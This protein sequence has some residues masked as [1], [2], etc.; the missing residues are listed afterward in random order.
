MFF[1][2][3]DYENIL[4]YIRNKGIKDSD[5]DEL[6]FP[7]S[8]EEYCVLTRNGKNYKVKIKNIYINPEKL[9]ISSNGTWV[10]NGED[11]GIQ[12]R[13][14]K[15]EKG[16]K[17]YLRYNVETGYIEYSYDQSAWENLISKEEFAAAAT[18][19]IG[20][21]TYS[22]GAHPNV[23]NSGTKAGAV[24]DFTLPDANTII[25]RNTK[26]I[27]PGSKA[28]VVNAGTSYDVVL[29]FNIPQG[30]KG[31]IGPKGDGFQ[32][33]G[34]VNDV[35]SL[36]SSG[37]LGD[38]YMVGTTS[39]YHI[40]MYNGSAYVDLGTATEIKAGVFDGGRADSVYGG[41][42]TVDCGGAAIE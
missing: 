6:G 1:T 40:Y 3:E 42:R 9:T 34:F 39:P 38:T 33:S 20:K 4:K 26:T 25:V 23:V 14:D 37:F 27:A 12:A 32:I 36:P 29:D 13:G 22:K 31:P 21:V 19:E 30:E 10:V 2:R 11:T 18:I 35:S 8:G 28:T 17:P 41:A 24:F 16:D 15:G 5:F 7:F